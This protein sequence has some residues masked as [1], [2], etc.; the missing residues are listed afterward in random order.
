MM[1][2]CA[3]HRDRQRGIAM[4]EFTIVAPLLL[5]LM[6][7]IAEFGR[8]LYQYNALNKAV[9]DAARYLATYAS[10]V[11]FDLNGIDPACLAANPSCTTTLQ[12]AVIALVRCGKTTCSGSDPLVVPN[13]AT[14]NVCVFLPSS[15]NVAVSTD[16]ASCPGKTQYKYQWILGTTLPLTSIDMNIALKTTTVM[17]AL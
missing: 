7:G 2:H 8:A 4:V 17:R 12:G 5:L 1:G 3:K 15:N 10:Q 9:R 16:S 11:N 6:F 14:T 13:L